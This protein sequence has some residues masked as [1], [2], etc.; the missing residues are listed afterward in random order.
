M[1]G[2]AHRPTARKS[3]NSLGWFVALTAGALA[4]AALIGA[5]LFSPLGC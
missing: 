5:V 2:S 3:L 1:L 4:A